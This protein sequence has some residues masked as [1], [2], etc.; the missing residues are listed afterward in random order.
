MSCL[1]SLV[2][3]VPFNLQVNS[4]FTPLDNLYPASFDTSALVIEMT[5]LFH[6]VVV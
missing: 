6:L 4:I 5:I 3:R 2:N 1:I